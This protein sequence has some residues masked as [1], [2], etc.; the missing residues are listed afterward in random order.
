[1]RLAALEGISLS[2]AVRKYSWQERAT[3]IA[4]YLEKAYPN[5]YAGER[6]D[7]DSLGLEIRFV[8]SVPAEAEE[9]AKEIAVPVRLRLSSGAISL[10]QLKEQM[11]ALYRNLCAD[12]EVEEANGSIDVEATSI[13]FAVQPT[14]SL[15]T[16]DPVARRALVD[17]LQ[18][19]VPTAV[20]VTTTISLIDK[21]CEDQDLGQVC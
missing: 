18:L 2:E 13:N 20:G 7:D 8:G 14:T 11:K 1:M 21:A 12:L 3:E 17:R 4:N 15:S 6:V 16:L 5:H 19:L 9:L 10:K